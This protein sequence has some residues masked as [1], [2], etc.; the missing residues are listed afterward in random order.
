MERITSHTARWSAKNVDDQSYQTVQSELAMATGG[1]LGVGVGAGRAKHVLPATTTDFIMATVAEEFGL[2]GALAVMAVLAGLVLRLLM[3]AQRTAA[4][5]ARLVLAGTAC[6][7]G[8]QSCVNI[9]MANGF[10][11]A[12]GIPVPFLS[13]GGSSLVALWLV[14]GICNSVL[15]PSPAKE[16]G[17]APR[18][19]RWRDRRTRLSRA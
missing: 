18:A 5:F 6:W 10:L 16:V 4:P 15:A 3:L 14:L 13:S 19:D 9:M 8:I 11:P 2:V 17:Y 12:I 7:L 1:V